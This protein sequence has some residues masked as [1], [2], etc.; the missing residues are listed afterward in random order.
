MTIRQQGGVFGR[1]PTFN[2]VDAT[3]VTTNGI[4]VNGNGVITDSL[5]VNTDALFVDGAT[6]RVGINNLT[7]ATTFDVAGNVYVSG[8]IRNTGGGSVSAPSIQPGLDGDT[9]MYWPASNTIGFTTAGSEK[10]RI[11]SSGGITFNGDTAVANALDDYEEGTWTPE[12]ADAG[13]GGNVGSATTATGSYVKIGKMVYL[14]CTLIDVD[15]TGMTS[16]NDFFIR[17]LPYASVGSATNRFDVG[18]LIGSGGVAFSGVLTPAVFRSDAYVRLV[19]T[20]SNANFDYTT[21]S[22]I[23]SG[24]ADLY[25]TLV[26]E[27]A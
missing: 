3:N 16:G 13:S 26:Y 2:D 10:L 20:V 8:I 23:T 22:Q 18:S 24:A 6:N 5:T 27:A 15:T 7:P 14:N 25:F 21:V 11:L 19:E 12:V 9:G 1:N 4:T 17:G